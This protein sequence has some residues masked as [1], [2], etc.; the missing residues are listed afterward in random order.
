MAKTR[1]PQQSRS[2]QTVAAIVEA[3]FITVSDEGV[4]GLTTRKVA[5]KAG[6][7]V[8]TLYEYFANKED[9]LEAMN[10]QFARDVVDMIRPMI[11]ELIKMPPRQA[12][13]DM[14]FEFRDLLQRDNGRYLHYAGRMA[15]QN[16]R[17]QIEPVTRV[18]SDLAMQ[19]LAHNPEY[20]R[21]PDIPVKAY[22]MI[23][24]GIATVI[25]QLSEESSPIT[26]EKLAEGLADMVRYMIEGGLRQADA[27]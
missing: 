20:T 23:H 22:I 19:Y 17:P 3:G 14:L 11:P 7:S 18:L 6:V 21:L 26:F 24:G 12:V 16:P 5:D 25:Q 15:G 13:L 10:A 27:G 4:E 9:I 1:K 8:G 2:R